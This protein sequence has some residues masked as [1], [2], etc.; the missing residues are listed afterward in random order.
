[1]PITRNVGDLG[2]FQLGMWAAEENAGLNKATND[3]YGWDF[4]L[5]FAARAESAQ[6]G[7]RNIQS[8]IQV[9]S[10][11]GLEEYTD[12][13]LSNWKRLIET[14]FPA[15][16][17][18]LHFDDRNTCQRAFLVHIW[19]DEVR[20]F[21]DR[22]VR[23]LSQGK[24]LKLNKRTMRL[25]WSSAQQLSD[26]SGAALIDAVGR[27]VGD[28]PGEYSRAKDDL[29]KKLGYEGGRWQTSV[30]IPVPQGYESKHPDELLVDAMFGLVPQ[31]D[32]IDGEIVHFDVAVQRRQQL[33]MP[34][35]TRAIMKPGK[36]TC[37]GN[38]APV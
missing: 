5:E 19:E 37:G 2:E 4:I 28:S 25:K 31:L 38:V 11:D 27:I 24:P 6:S 33:P 1:M 36:R 21:F 3:K 29:R 16:V 9:K 14:S 12:I 23:L 20:R 13:L 8:F 30:R 35:G 22:V 7:G 10:T 26:L 32:I 18:A 17:L 34:P 15:F